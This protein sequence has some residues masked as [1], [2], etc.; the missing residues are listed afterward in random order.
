MRRSR[1][2]EPIAFA[3]KGEQRPSP[4]YDKG[5]AAFRARVAPRNSDGF[6]LDHGPLTIFASRSGRPLS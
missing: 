5:F 2:L 1:T 4:S 6:G 3:K